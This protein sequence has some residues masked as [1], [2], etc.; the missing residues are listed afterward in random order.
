MTI[1]AGRPTRNESLVPPKVFTA[2]AL[3]ATG[4]SFD[5]A[6][7]SVSMTGKSLRKWR[8]HKDVKDYLEEI[9][10]ENI[11]IGTNLLASRN[12]LY[13]KKLDEII[14]NPNT[15]DYNKIDAIKAAHM[16]QKENVLDRQQNRKLNEIREI[17]IEKDSGRS[18]IDISE[19]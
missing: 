18:L 11:D 19:N 12:H 4:T 13:M 9:P 1:A 14:M 2:L 16:I 7:E 8:S 10:R 5:A 3:V 17:L 6:A 15:S